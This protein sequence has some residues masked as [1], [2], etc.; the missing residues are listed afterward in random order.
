[1]AQAG[2]YPFYNVGPDGNG[3]YIIADIEA[4]RA[5]LVDPALQ[6]HTLLDYFKRSGIT[7][8]Y[9]INTHGHGDHTF[10][11][12][13]FKENTGAKLLIHR[14]DLSMLERQGQRTTFGG[15]AATPSPL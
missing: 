10:N 5:A 15:V 1:M 12:A 4:K 3:V 2:F 8:D 11:N 13:Y 14:G 6:S 7:L 9:I